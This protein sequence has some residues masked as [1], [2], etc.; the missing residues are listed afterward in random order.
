AFLV[1]RVGD[2]GF[3]LGILLIYLTFGTIEFE[4]VFRM[5]QEGINQYGDAMLFDVDGG[6]VDLLDYDP[7]AGTV[8]AITGKGYKTL[9]TSE[10]KTD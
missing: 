7:S 5:A 2:F 3:G 1:N 10:L 4:P 8:V 6:G 9:R